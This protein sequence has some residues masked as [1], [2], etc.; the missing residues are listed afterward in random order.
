MVDG[1]INGWVGDLIDESMCCMRRWLK[2][3]QVNDGKKSGLNC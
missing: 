2:M 3:K 1:L